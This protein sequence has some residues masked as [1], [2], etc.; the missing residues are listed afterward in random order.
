MLNYYWQV[1]P[2]DDMAIPAYDLT[3]S[4]SNM[5]DIIMLNYLLDNASRE[6]A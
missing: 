1:Q 2:N 4:L 5:S 3:S 6:K